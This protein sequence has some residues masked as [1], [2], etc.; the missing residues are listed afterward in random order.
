MKMQKN[1][2]VVELDKQLNKK[3]NEKSSELKIPKKVIITIALN[4]FLDDIEQL[5]VDL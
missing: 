5:G 2:I 3:L 1:K 4:K